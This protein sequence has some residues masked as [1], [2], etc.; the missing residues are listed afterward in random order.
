[1]ATRC[2]PAG[3]TQS[4]AS[5]QCEPR[6]SQILADVMKEIGCE[7]DF[8]LFRNS[9]GLAKYDSGA[10]VRYGLCVGS[11]DLIGILSPTGRLV[12]LEL[13]TRTGR[14]T[15]EQ[16][17]WLAMVR[18]MGGFGCVVRSAS[19]ARAALDRARSGAS[20]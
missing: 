12:S 16:I 10:K 8:R 3:P 2:A 7:P 20:E 11:S 15:K 13:K 18:R 14:A 6:E 4:G 1:M 19:E 17:A 9:V 5:E